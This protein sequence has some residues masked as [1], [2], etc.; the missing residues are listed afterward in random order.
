MGEMCWQ[1]IVTHWTI[2]ELHLHALFQVGSIPFFSY[3]VKTHT[4]TQVIRPNVNSYSAESG[5][6]YHYYF[7]PGPGV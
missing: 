5:H 6:V 2:L 1:I 4:S 7:L 3:C